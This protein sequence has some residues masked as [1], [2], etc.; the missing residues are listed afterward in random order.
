MALALGARDED[1]PRTW[2]G[3][4]LYLAGE[5]TSGRIEVGPDAR[6]IIDAVL[7]P[8]L[9]WVSGPAAWVNRLVTIGLLPE[10]IRAGYRYAWSDRRQRQLRRV[11][12]VLRVARHA[13]PRVLAYWRPARSAASS[14]AAR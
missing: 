7:F 3:L 2:A 8:P 13:T 6:A 5:L 1:L 14:H 10:R 9:S 11:L 4:Q 12:A